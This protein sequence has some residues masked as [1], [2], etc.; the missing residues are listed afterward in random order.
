MNATLQK[1]GYPATLIKEYQ[2]WVVVLRPQQVT[3]G[4]LVLICQD[5]AS[6][7]SQIS[8]EAFAELPCAIREIEASVSEAFSYE[9]INYLMLMMV[10]PDV[11]FHVIPRYGTEHTFCHQQF[12]DHGWPGPPLLKKPNETSQDM[13]QKIL[14]HL[15]KSWVHKTK[16]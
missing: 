13:I 7:F 15:K 14:T 2:K 12:F 6:A 4:S 8:P 9:K 10:D 1:F 16:L 3:L 11:H 5:V